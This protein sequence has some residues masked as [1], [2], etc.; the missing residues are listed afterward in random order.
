MSTGA[1]STCSQCGATILATT[2]TCTGGLCMA[3]KQGIRKNIEESKKYY[4]QQ[5]TDPFRHHWK[6]L[7]DRVHHAPDGFYRLS[8]PEQTCYLVSAFL[9]EVYNGGIGQFF[10]NSSGDLYQE[11]L[12]ALEEIGAMRCHALLQAA[13]RALFQ[14]ADPPRDRAARSAAMPEYPEAP[15]APR[16]DWDLELDRLSEEFWADPDELAE[17]LRAYAVEHRLVRI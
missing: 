14:D 4:Q 16:P 7:I 13:K 8:R 17:K 5:R 2:A 15:G 9:G 6:A 10:D 11:T 3:C 1:K 12:K